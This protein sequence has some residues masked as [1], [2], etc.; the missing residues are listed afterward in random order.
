[1]NS[2]M[3]YYTKVNKINLPNGNYIMYGGGQT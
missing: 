1:M 2:I 3:K